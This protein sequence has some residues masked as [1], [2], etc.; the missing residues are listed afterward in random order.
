MLSTERRRRAVHKLA[1]TAAALAVCVLPTACDYSLVNPAGAPAGPTGG[2]SGDDTDDPVV[3]PV[4]NTSNSAPTTAGQQ[5]FRDRDRDRDRR[6]RDR[7]R[8]RTPRPTTPPVANPPVVDPSNPEEPPP[9]SNPE[10][11]PPPPSSENP[12]PGAASGVVPPG[13]KDGQDNAT[14]LTPDTVL[15]RDCSKSELPLHDG[16]Q[17]EGATCVATQMGEVAATGDLP[18]LMITQAPANVEVGAAFQLVVS[19]R[20]LVRDR[21]LGAAVGGYYLEASFLNDQGLQRGHFHTG[22][23]MIS[24]NVNEPPN[25]APQAE[26]SPFFVATQ[27]GGGGADADSVTIDVPG[28]K[29]AQA[30]IMQCASWAGDGS[31]RTPMMSFANQI[32][33]FDT[34]RITIGGAAAAPVP[35][36]P[37]AE[38]PATDATPAPESTEPAANDNGAAQQEGDNNAEAE[39]PASDAPASNDADEP[40]APASNAAASGGQESLDQ[41]FAELREQRDAEEN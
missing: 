24:N 4:G 41:R 10:E 29:T 20:N 23:R 33:A 28:D 18:Q 3:V 27:D 34:V 17:S 32:P 19:T 36:E 11:P 16:F 35:A 13:G 14:T 22:C 12:A 26:R 30:G 6:D 38:A 8:T 39:Q 21:F 40:A 1:V 15:G 2:T 25:A 7:T 5:R 37:P 31:H 9:A